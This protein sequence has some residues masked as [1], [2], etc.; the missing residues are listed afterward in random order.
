MLPAQLFLYQIASTEGSDH[1]ST[2]QVRPHPQ[3]LTALFPAGSCPGTSFSTP[4][5]TEASPG[6]LALPTLLILH[7]FPRRPCLCRQACFLHCSQRLTA[8]LTVEQIKKMLQHCI[9]TVKPIRMYIPESHA[10]PILEPSAALSLLET[11]MVT[12]S[13][14]VPRWDPGRLAGA[15]G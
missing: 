12:V 4:L 2:F 6:T 3:P 5:P 11:P 1:R 9:L 10:L 15:S 14:R 8:L 7:A 13:H